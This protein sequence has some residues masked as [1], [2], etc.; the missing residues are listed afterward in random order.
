M[1]GSN[2]V[3]G[4]HLHTCVALLA[5]AIWALTVLSVQ[6]APQKMLPFQPQQTRVLPPDEANAITAVSVQAIDFWIDYRHVERLPVVT[7]SDGASTFSVM[8]DG[9]ALSFLS[10]EEQGK[11]NIYNTKAPLKDGPNHIALNIGD[12]TIDFWVNGH[13]Q[14]QALGVGFSPLDEQAEITITL[15]GSRFDGN[16]GAFRV[17][18][19]GLDDAEVKRS[20]TSP[21]TAS[22]RDRERRLLIA[23]TPDGTFFEPLRPRLGTYKV[24]G[25]TATRTPAN[26]RG[27]KTVDGAPLH[28]I[29]DRERFFLLADYQNSLILQFDWGAWLKLR[30]DPDDPGSLISTDPRLSW[31]GRLRFNKGSDRVFT[32]EQVNVEPGSPVLQNGQSYEFIEF[33]HTKTNKDGPDLGKTWTI[34]DIPGGFNFSRKGCFDITQMDLADPSTGECQASVFAWPSTKKGAVSVGVANRLVPTGWVSGDQ[35][36]QEVGGYITSFV[37]SASDLTQNQVGGSGQNFSVLGIGVSKE[38]RTDKNRQLRYK[39]ER[40]VSIHKYMA[41]SHAILLQPIKVRL[42]N[43]FVRRVLRAAPGATPPP[44]W[45]DTENDRYGEG[46]L[47]DDDPCTES[48]SGPNLV[49]IT[50]SGPQSI[51]NQIIANHGTH[52]SYAARYGAIGFRYSYFDKETIG[53]L[54]GDQTNVKKAIGADL[55]KMAQV[56]SKA[57]NPEKVDLSAQFRT[58]SG[59]GSSFDVHSLVDNA[60]E[61]FVC[62]GGSGCAEGK[63][64][65]NSTSLIPVFLQLRPLDELLAPPYFTDPK[66]TIELRQRLRKALA[67][68]QTGSPPSQS[69]VVPRLT[70][71]TFSD[72]QCSTKSDALGK[73]LCPADLSAELEKNL[74]VYIYG[75]DKAGNP[76]DLETPRVFP[77]SSTLGKPISFFGRRLANGENFEKLAM[78]LVPGTFLPKAD[79]RVYERSG[80]WADNLCNRFVPVKPGKTAQLCEIPY[81]IRGAKFT[82]QS[83]DACAAARLEGALSGDS[84]AGVLTGGS[85]SEEYQECIDDL[86]DAGLD[87]NV[88]D[89][90][91]NIRYGGAH[92]STGRRGKQFLDGSFLTRESRIDRP[93]FSPTTFDT[94]LVSGIKLSGQAYV[95]AQSE[96]ETTLDAADGFN[97]TLKGTFRRADI[98]EEL[99]YTTTPAAAIVDNEPK[100][101]A[102]VAPLSVRLANVPFEIRL[103]NKGVYVARYAVRYTVG[104]VHKQHTTKNLISG[105]DEML[106]LPPSAEDIEVIAEYSNGFR[107][108]VISAR[109]IQ[110]DRRDVCFA[111]RGTVFKPRLSNCR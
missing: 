65:L 73:F 86:I 27:M 8:A 33:F 61:L 53:T 57:P 31:I 87:E 100:T 25:F 79:P 101:L 30:T 82:T 70:Q 111:T 81:E 75:I 84:I 95:Y 34:Q 47:D 69:S 83:F 14:P 97:I 23:Q 16:I 46:S 11:K 43:C 37:E 2:S 93:T 74:A 92:L 76:Y 1:T 68:Y 39:S 63:P 88:F 10:G 90:A 29:Y 35:R 9:A 6:A 26:V 7:L 20:M 41:T 96:N 4:F 66:I 13:K 71:L 24:V 19:V 15:G 17:W 99:G 105:R 59:S 50:D 107:F 77:L 55:G 102:D 3:R 56:V 91:T 54:I 5:V 58:E 80:P 62:R 85:L 52:F 51:A 28:S 45:S 21:D 110:Q 94:P 64:E 60:K 42:H 106:W 48:V 104:K 32:A 78:T 49:P 22:V 38:T 44:Y 98:G 67:N 109:L 40:T 18:S 108:K 36:T 72:I 89:I 12:S 103:E